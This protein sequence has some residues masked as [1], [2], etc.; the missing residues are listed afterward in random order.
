MHKC[1]LGASRRDT[2]ENI[3]NGTENDNPVFKYSI[4]TVCHPTGRVLRAK[5][6]HWTLYHARFTL[7]RNRL[8]FGYNVQSRVQ[9]F[10]SSKVLGDR[11]ARQMQFNLGQLNKTIEQ[12]H[13]TTRHFS[14]ILNLNKWPIELVLIE[15]I[16][17][18][19]N[20]VDQFSNWT[21][22][23]LNT[24]QLNIKLLNK[25]RATIEQGSNWTNLKL[26]KLQLN[27]CVLDELTCSKNYCSVVIGQLSLFNWHIND[28]RMEGAR[29]ITALIRRS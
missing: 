26:A 20:H 12:K 27:N 21:I 7:L 13:N 2:A 18:E 16:D 6:I 17:I 19:Q 28:N 1:S 15:Q 11:S 4:V 5:P 3:I 22:S 14:S 8:H 24:I 10:I 23:W 25:Y 29:S 9:V